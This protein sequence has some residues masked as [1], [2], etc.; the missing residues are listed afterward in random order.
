[1]PNKD[2]TGPL[3]KGPR[4]G[5]ERG[6]CEGANPCGHNRNFKNCGHERRGFGCRKNLTNDSSNKRDADLVNTNDL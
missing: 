4:T 5:K 2:G 1:M 6:N 3:G